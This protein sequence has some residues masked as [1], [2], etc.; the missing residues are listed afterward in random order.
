MKRLTIT[1]IAF[2]LLLAACGAEESGTRATSEILAQTIMAETQAA[3]PS[4]TPEPTF[5][6]TSILS[7]TIEITSTATHTSTPTTTSTP[8]FIPSETAWFNTNLTT[9][10]R[11]EN[12]TEDSIIV[13]LSGAYNASFT[14]VASWNL[15]IP[16]GDYFYSVWIGDNSEHSGSFIITNAD[17]H[18]MVISEGKVRFKYP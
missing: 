2:S 14:F 8:E 11:F 18:T 4:E 12:N 1:I 13:I 5:T 16:R 3:I 17:K 6:K 10:L 7:P 15:D 9:R